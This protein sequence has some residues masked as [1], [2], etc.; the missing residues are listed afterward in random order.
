MRGELYAI[1]I[2]LI[3][4][5]KQTLGV[6][7]FPNFSLNHK[8]P[9]R[10]SDIDPE[11]KGC[12]V[13]AI[14]GHGA[15]SRSLQ[16]ESQDFKQLPEQPETQCLTFITGLVESALNGVHEVVAGR[17]AFRGRFSRE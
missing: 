15:F 7:R 3:V 16:S 4:D 5:G 13:Y 10:N 17:R 6:V 9:L 12:I 1:N 11:G 14:K 8:K 2:G